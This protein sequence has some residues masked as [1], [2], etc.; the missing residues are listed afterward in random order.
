MFI[1][2][3]DRDNTP[4]IMICCG[5][6]RGEARFKETYRLLPNV[7]TGRIDLNANSTYLILCL[8]S[9]KHAGAI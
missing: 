8:L 5:A 2:G 1:Y 6:S 3:G 7:S 9:V 4:A